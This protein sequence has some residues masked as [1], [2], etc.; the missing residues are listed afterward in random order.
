[1]EPNVKSP[2]DIINYIAS[3]PLGSVTLNGKRAVI[4]GFLNEWAT[5][6]TMTQPRISATFSWV[7][8]ERVLKADGAFWT[9]DAALR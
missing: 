8:V 6:E 3:L 4:C 5:V 7:E 2:E 1:M 9:G